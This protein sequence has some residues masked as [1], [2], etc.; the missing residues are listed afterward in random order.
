[1]NM[2]SQVV[3]GSGG[4]LEL[5]GYHAYM[6]VWNPVQDQTLLLKRNQLTPRIIKNA[7]AVLLED[8]LYETYHITSLSISLNF[9]EGISTKR[10]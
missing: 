2:A 5:Q 6:G 7:V 3:V 1:M 4:S 10:S 9:Y 8:Q